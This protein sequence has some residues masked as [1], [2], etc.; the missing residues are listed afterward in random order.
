MNASCLGDLRALRA[1]HVNG[2]RCVV[3]TLGPNGTS[4]HVASQV[5]RQIAHENGL[6]TPAVQ[7]LPTFEAVL[8]ALEQGQVDLALVPSA[9][10]GATDFHWSPVIRLVLHF[11]H[12]TPGYGLAA[13]E[14]IQPHGVCVS[15]ASMP[16]VRRLFADLHPGVAGADNLIWVDAPS[17]VTAARMVADGDAEYALTNE[18]GRR[19]ANL[20][21]ISQRD[22]AYIVWMVFARTATTE[23]RPHATTDLD[24]RRSEDSQSAINPVET[25]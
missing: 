17:T 23:A 16:E 21:W 19:T 5:L 20:T 11:V 25:Q 15:V 6:P 9:Y 24:D 14:R 3:A 18:L 13:R 12:Q 10:R 7:L 2:K 8:D 4:S 1:L 22:G